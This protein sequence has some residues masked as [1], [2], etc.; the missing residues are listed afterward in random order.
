MP[1]ADVFRGKTVLATVRMDVETE[2]NKSQLHKG[3]RVMMKQADA[4][5]AYLLLGWW[6]DQSACSFAVILRWSVDMGGGMH[7]CLAGSEPRSMHAV[8]NG[9]SR[10]TCSLTLSGSASAS[11]SANG[12]ATS[13]HGSHRDRMTEYTTWVALCRHSGTRVPAQA[14][15]AGGG[16]AGLE[17]R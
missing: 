16:P 10:L 8:G 5:Q 3:T 13:D 9:R 12:L 6:L 11:A 2:A 15:G 17:L 14:T 4:I 1:A 7:G